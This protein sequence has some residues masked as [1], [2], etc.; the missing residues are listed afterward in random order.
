VELEAAGAGTR[1]V[2]T[3]QG[4]FF[5]GANGPSSRKQGWSELLERLA[6]TL[7]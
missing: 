3:E 1:L 4:A 5:E 7:G 2:Y 6:A